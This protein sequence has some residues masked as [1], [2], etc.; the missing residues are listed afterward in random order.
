MK[1]QII[2]VGNGSND[3]PGN[4]TPKE[5]RIIKKECRGKILHLFCGKSNIGDIRVDFTF[6]NIKKDVFEFLKE[7]KEYFNTI[8]IDAPYNQKF[9][10]KYQK[11]GNTP[12]QFII[13]AETERTTELFKYIDRISPEIIILKSWNYFCLKRYEIDKCYLCYPGGY[14]KS[15]FLIIMKRKQLSLEAFK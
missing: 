8:I 7:N 12:K 6:G 9:A 14:R 1:I 11:I 10:D 3:Y 15:T 4:F 2:T 13:F 5:I